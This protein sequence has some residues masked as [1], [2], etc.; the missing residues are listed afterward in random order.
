MALGVS[1]FM[2]AIFMLFVIQ[3]CWNCLLLRFPRF[4]QTHEASPASDVGTLLGG[5]DTL[6]GPVFLHALIY[7]AARAYFVLT[8]EPD[9]NCIGEYC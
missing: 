2:C 6:A 8:T 5:G 7:V 1:G 4:S 9:I 3:T